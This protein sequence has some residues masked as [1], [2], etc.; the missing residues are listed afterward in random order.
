MGQTL[1]A[2]F[3]T[4]RSAEIA[5]EHLVQFVRRARRTRQVSE[6]TMSGLRYCVV[7][8]SARRA[9]ANRRARPRSEVA[10]RIWTAG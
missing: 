6:V 3:D 1:I 8:G 2:H 10:W 4:R 7:S 5:V 9:L